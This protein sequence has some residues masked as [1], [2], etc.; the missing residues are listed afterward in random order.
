[1]PEKAVP[2][3]SQPF[4]SEYH[5]RSVNFETLT[6][7][8]LKIASQSCRYLF[9]K[10]DSA[11]CGILRSQHLCSL[12]FTDIMQIRSLMNGFLY[13]CFCKPVVRTDC[14]GHC[15]PHSTNS[16]KYGTRITFLQNQHQIQTYFWRHHF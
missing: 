2:R 10:F 16:I 5:R 15:K 1:M 14:F 11:L 6:K 8:I 3:D 9:R 13:Y 4:F 12:Y 7:I